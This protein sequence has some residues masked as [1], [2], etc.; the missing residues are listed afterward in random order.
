PAVQA[1][2]PLNGLKIK[3]STDAHL[4]QGAITVFDGGAY[5][6][7]AKIDD[8]QP[9]TERLVSYAL[10]LDVEVAPESKGNPEQLLSV[11]LKKGVIYSEGKYERTNKYVI[12]NSGKKAKNV[13]IEYPRDTSWTLIAPKKPSE[14]TR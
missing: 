12:K 6:G 4:M 7:D 8:L 5:A 2:H 9:G 14:E 10:D 3:N 13:L 1:K 11:H